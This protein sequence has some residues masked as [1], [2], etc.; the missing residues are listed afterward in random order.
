M[1]SV[2]LLSMKIRLLVFF[3]TV[4]LLLTT[5]G[6]AR[7]EDNPHGDVFKNRP[8]PAVVDFNRDVRP[9]LSEKCFQCHGADEKAR[10]AKLRLDV[11]AEA[12]KERDGTVAV[13]PKD[14]D[15]SEVMKRIL[16]TDP[17]EV[18]PP[19]T[20]GHALSPRETEIVRKWISQGA[21]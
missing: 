16:S 12:L 1:R 10:K 13:K 14:A 15:N 17:D 6:H 3:S 5:G 11:R 18:M 2:L 20:E 19:P 9:V 4:L 7:S 21:A 8:V